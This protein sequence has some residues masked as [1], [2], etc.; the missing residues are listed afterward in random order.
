MKRRIQF[1]GN[2]VRDRILL[3]SCPGNKAAY[4]DREKLIRTRSNR[5]FC[6]TLVEVCAAHGSTIIASKNPSPLP[7][8]QAVCRVIPRHTVEG[9]GQIDHVF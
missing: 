1:K 9:M 5:H 3:V 6:M 8:V 4:V 7:T 2:I